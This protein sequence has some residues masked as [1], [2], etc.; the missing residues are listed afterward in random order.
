MKIQRDIFTAIE[1]GTG[2][3]KVLMGEILPD[4]TLSVLG[5]GTA[6][7]LNMCKGEPL[8]PRL[9]GEQVVMALNRAQ[10]AAR[11]DIPGPVF[12]AVSGPY[13]ASVVAAET[14]VLSKTDEV[15]EIS[16][17]H[18]CALMRKL[19]E[20][21]ALPDKQS[22]QAC[23]KRACISE[24]RVSFNPIGL[25][26]PSLEI[27]AQLFQ[28]D[29]AR[30]AAITALV[31]EALGTLVVSNAIYAP[32]ADC[33]AVFPPE[34]LDDTSF[35]LLVNLG[36]GMTSAVMP[37][38]RGTPF[39]CQIPVG[40]DHLANDLA[41]A[42]DLQISQARHLLA[43]LGAFRCTAIASK[44]GR[45]RMIDVQGTA[46]AIPAAAVELVIEARLRE[47]FGLLWQRLQQEKMDVWLGSQIHLCG[48]GAGIPRVTELAGQVFNRRQVQVAVPYKVSGRADFRP[49]P[50]YCTVIGTLRAGYRQ[51]QSDQYRE[52]RRSAWE[53]LRDGAGW[54]KQILGEW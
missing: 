48:G 29:R 8:A 46:R 54:L 43:R 35:S 3:I 7:S 10:E 40:G 53:R 13:I 15:G 39:C 18:F 11:M 4:N 12:L 25:Y 38:S 31:N 47:I 5:F 2:S 1:L 30:L 20:R 21:E 24:G 17:E 14:M 19:L 33:A 32:L 27:E 51:H 41:I 44:D 16:E 36:A 50:Q 22:L 45:S 37:S 26:S 52:A 23:F 34:G 6:E 49:L 28:A 42:F 9:V